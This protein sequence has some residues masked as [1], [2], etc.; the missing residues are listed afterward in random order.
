MDL[1]KLTSAE[2]G[3]LSVESLAALPPHPLRVLAE[4]IR[5]AHNVGAILRTADAVRAAHVYL[6]GFTPPG[7]HRLV[8]KS[9]LGAQD[10][11]PWSR[12][13]DPLEAIALA[14]A[15]GC[16]IVALEQT[17]RA[18]SLE[19]F[20]LDD[21]PVCLVLGNEVDG[22]SDR[23]LAE[24]DRAVELDQFGVKHSLNVSVAFGIAAYDLLRLWKR[25]SAPGPAR[26]LFAPPTA[27]E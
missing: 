19:A 26:P 9:A 16:L 8:H 24:C 21:F 25:V 14:R 27:H 15:A 6:A 4:D 1:R 5:S 13:E 23:V 18:A 20:T 2:L 22:V 3:R 17:N 11:V 10:T 7:D 12:H